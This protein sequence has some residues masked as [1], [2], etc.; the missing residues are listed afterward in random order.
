MN[1]NIKFLVSVNDGGQLHT[2][3]YSED[4]YNNNVMP[5][6]SKNYTPDQYSVTGL[7][8]T[9]SDNITE[10]NQYLISVS[11]NGHTYSKPYSGKDL[12]GGKLTEISRQFPDY[13]IQYIDGAVRVD[14][15][16]DE[17][18]SI[19]WQK[20]L[21]NKF[22]QLVKSTTKT[23]EQTNEVAEEVKSTSLSDLLAERGD[24]LRNFANMAVYN[25]LTKTPEELE[26]MHAKELEERE[27]RRREQ[28]DVQRLEETRKQISEINKQL[29][30][31]SVREQAA[32]EEDFGG[33]NIDWIVK[34][35]E[36]KAKL[37]KK[38][39]ELVKQQSEN[40]MY[41]K[42]EKRIEGIAED[43]RD[44]A[45]KVTSDISVEG[46]LVTYN[47]PEADTWQAARYFADNAL[48]TI[49]APDDTANGF[50][51]FLKGAGDTFSDVDFWTM[52]LESISSNTK[53]KRVFNKIADKVN[54]YS[55]KTLTETDFDNILTDA[56]KELIK[57][58]VSTS[59]A[60]ALRAYDTNNMY[61]AGSIAADSVGF[62]AQFILTGGVGDAFAGATKTAAK[63]FA[64]WIA[65]NTGKVGKRAAIDAAVASQT[66]V[67]RGAVKLADA[68]ATPVLKAV[69]MTLMQTGLYKNY[70]EKLTERDD[71]G[72][73]TYDY[74]TA[75]LPAL[76]D[77]GLE[78]WSEMALEPVLAVFGKT[79]SKGIANLP[80][81]SK[82]GAFM[83]TKLDDITSF[84][85]NREAIDLLTKAGFDGYFEEIGE[86]ILAA[87]VSSMWEPEAWSQF[88]EKDNLISMAVAF[89]PMS[90]IGGGMSMANYVK[91]TMA[92]EEAAPAV[93]DMLL[94]RTNITEAQLNALFDRKSATMQDIADKIS[95]IVKPIIESG[96]ISADEFKALYDFAGATAQKDIAQ[97]LMDRMTTDARN[98]MRAELNEKT[99]GKTIY[100]KDKDGNETV[101]I[102]TDANGKKRYVIIDETSEDTLALS[103][104]EQGGNIKIVDPS[105][106]EITTMPAN[107]YLDAQV[108]AAKQVEEQN[109]IAQQQKQQKQSVME[110]LKSRKPVKLYSPVSNL[111]E[112]YIFL[113]WDG[114][115]AVVA[116]AQTGDEERRTVQEMANALNISP[117][118]LTKDQ[119][120][121]MQV[122]K[123]K[124]YDSLARSANDY[125]GAPISYGDVSGSLLRVKSKGDEQGES[126]LEAQIVTESG[127][128][129]SVNVTPQQIEDFIAERKELIANAGAEANDRR[130]KDRERKA[131]QAKDAEQYREAK[132]KFINPDGSI[133]EG[134][135]LENDPRS[136]AIY[137]DGKYGKKDTDATLRAALTK[138]QERAQKAL[139]A[140]DNE[141]NPD[142]KQPLRDEYDHAVAALDTLDG[143]IAERNMDESASGALTPDQASEKFAEMEQM[144]LTSDE[145][146]DL[147]LQS[148]EET[149]ARIDAIAKP[150]VSTDIPAYMEEKRKYAELVAAE[151]KKIDYWRSILNAPMT[152]LERQNPDMANAR[153]RRRMLDILT[154]KQST[155]DAETLARLDAELQQV[156]E[157]FIGRAIA[158]INKDNDN[159]VIVTEASVA[160]RM[161]ELGS[162]DSTI[163]QVL[164]AIS[165]GDQPK[166]F[167]DTDT[168]VIY[169]V[170]ENNFDVRDSQITFV[171]ERQHKRTRARGLASV[172]IDRLGLT[173]L[174]E[175]EKKSALLAEMHKLFRG[176]FYDGKSALTIADELISYGVERVFRGDIDGVGLNETITNFVKNIDNERGETSN[177]SGAGAAS[178]GGASYRVGADGNA[179]VE[180]VGTTEVGGQGTGSAVGGEEESEGEVA[181]ANGSPIQGLESYS[182]DELKRLIENHIANTL[183]GNGID[184]DIVAIELHGSRGRGTARKDSDLDAVVEYRGDIREDSMFNILNDEDSR[185]V[186]D[187]IG[188]DI[189]PIRAEETGTMESYMKR[190]QEYDAQK[191]QQQAASENEA[192]FRATLQQAHDSAATS[193]NGN[194]L[195]AAFNK[196]KW[197]EG[198]VNLDLGGGKFDN[199]TEFLKGKGVENLIFDPFNRDAEWNKR[200]AEQ[201]Q[202][203]GVDSVTCNNVLNVIDNEASRENVIL[204]ASKAIKPEG[205]AYFYIYEGDKSGIGKDKGQGRWQ[206]NMTTRQYI[207]EISKYF[208]DVKRRGQLIEAKN[209]LPTDEQSVWSFTGAYDGNNE[210]RFSVANNNQQIFVSNALASL[211][212]IQMKSGNA[213]AWVNKIQQAGGLKKEEDKWIGLTDW[214]KE[215]QGDISKEDVAEYIREHQIRIEE[216]HYAG[217]AE[218]DAENTYAMVER[219]L[220][221]K[222]SNYIA[223]YY[224]QNNGENDDLYGSDSYEYALD[225][226]RKEMNDEFPYAI[227]RSH[228][229]VYLT[230]PYEETDDLQKWADKLG[231]NFAPQ[232][233]INST[234]LDYTTDGLI[235][236]REIALVVPTIEPYNKSDNIHFGDAGEGRAVAWIRFGSSKYYIPEYDNFYEFKKRI[237]EKYFPGTFGYNIPDLSKLTDEERAEYDRLESIKKSVPMNKSRGTVLVIDEIQSKRHQDGKEKGYDSVPD[238]PFR[239]SWDALAMKRM[240]RLAAE[241]GYDKIAWTSGQMQSDRYGLTKNLGDFYY[242]PNEDGTY[243][244]SA[245]LNQRRPGYT[246]YSDLNFDS[247]TVDRIGEIFGKEIA[248]KVS[249]G[250]GRKGYSHNDE[251]DWVTFSGRELKMANEGMRYFYDQ[252]LVNWM[253]K[254]G[255]K[256]GVQVSDL[257][258]MNLENKEGWHSIDITPEM[259]ESVMEGQPMFRATEI[260]GN[261]SLIAVHNLTENNL[262]D[263]FD[264]GGFPMPSIAITKA[265]IGHTN[266]GDISLVFDKETIN[267]K[268]RKNKVYSGDAWTP[269]FPKIGYKLNYDKTREIYWRAIDVGDLP[270]FIPSRFER[271]NYE[272]NIDDMQAKSL[273]DN[274]KKDYGAKQFFLAE[275]GN[276][277]REYEMHEVDKYTEEQVQRFKEVLEKIGFENLRGVDWNLTPEILQVVRETLDVKSNVEDDIIKKIARRYVAN[278][279]DYATHG[280]KKSE[281]DYDATRRKI[282][283]RID[284]SA[285]EKWLEDLFSGIVEKRGIRN[286]VDPFTPIGNRRAWEKLYDEVTLDNVVKAMSKKPK[287][288]GS[289][290]FGG[291]IFGASAKTYNS[292][293][294]IRKEAASRLAAVKPEE[295]EKQKQ[296]ILDRLSEVKVTNKEL[297]LTEMFDLTE[298]IRDAVAKSHTADGIHRYLKD[299]YPDI[300]M[301]A[302]QEIADIVKDIQ[303]I[304][305]KYFEAKPYRAVGF[306]EVK[307]A[308][309]PEG[310][311]QA[312]VDGLLER[313]VPVR[314]YEKAN[315]QERMDIISNATEEMGLRFRTIEITPEVRDEMYQIEALARLKG[316]YLKAPNGADTK[317]NPEQWAMVRTKKFKDWFGDWELAAKILNIVTVSQNHGFKNFEEAKKWA[318]ANIVRT[319]SNEETG[320]KGEIRISNNAISKFL[321]ESA[322]SK[323]ES[324][325]IHLSVLK[326]LPD[327]IK[328]SLDAEQHPDY[329]KG[330]DGV[331]S[332]KNGI[333]EGVTIHRLYGA[334]SIDGQVYRTKV[335]IKEYADKNRPQKAYSY[336][337]TKIELFAGTLV[338]ADSSNPNTNNSIS[339]ANLLNGVEKSYS[340]GEYLIDSSK[341]VDENGE[342][343]VV[344]HGT[345]REF[346][347]FGNTDSANELG[348]G[349]YFT[350][351]RR[352][353]EAYTNPRLTDNKGKIEARAMEIFIDDMGHSEE[354]SYD[355]EFVHDY[356]EAYDMAETELFGKPRVMSGFLNVRNPRMV[357]DNGNLEE[358]QGEHDGVIDNTFGKRHGG[359]MIQSRAGES[360]M[361]VMVYNPNQIKSATDNNGEFSRE[362]DD[363]R[364]RVIPGGASMAERAYRES[365]AF[366]FTGSE[367]ISS[368][369][370]VAF[371]FRELENYATENSFIVF[372]KDGM[373]TILHTG[374]GDMR[375]TFVDTAAAV[376][377]YNDF[378]PDTVYLVHNHPSGRLV[379]SAAD[380]NEL[381]KLKDIFSGVPVGGIILDTVSGNY[382]YFD[383]GIN[384]EKTM[385]EEGDEFPVKV[386]SFDKIVFDK[387][388][389][390][391]LNERKIAGS[392]DVAAF[393]SA[394]RL[395][396]GKKLG[397]LLLNNAQYIVANYV[398]N[399]N[400]LTTRNADRIARQ[401][402]SVAVHSNANRVIMFGNFNFD[403]KSLSS[404]NS[405][406]KKASGETMSLLDVV[407]MNPD[408]GY[409]SVTN[410]TLH[411]RNDGTMFRV[412]PAQDAE[413]MDAVE[414]GDMEKAERMVRD[415]AMAAGYNLEAY[416]G[417]DVDFN[418]FKRV[419]HTNGNIWGSGFYF[420]D[421]EDAAA[422]WGERAKIANSSGDYK[423]LHT[424]LSVHNPLELYSD[425]LE[426]GLGEYAEDVISKLD[427]EYDADI[428][429]AI[430]TET[431]IDDYRGDAN[432]R[433]ADAIQELGFDAIQGYYY[434]EY[435]TMVFSP[436]QVKSA[437]P[438]TYDD[439]GK[440]IPL[441]E[442]FNTESDDIRFRIS[443]RSSEG[444]NL[445]EGQQAYFANSKAV[446][447]KGNLL[448]LYHGTSR[449]GFNEFRSGFF[450]TSKK[451]ADSYG[452]N[453]REGKLYDPNEQAS[454]EKVIAGDF[455]LG[456]MTFDSEEDRADFLAK[457]PL[458]EDAMTLSQ[459]NEAIDNAYYDGDAELEKELESKRDA[460]KKIEND[461]RDYEFDH[462]VTTTWN[463]LLANPSAYTENDFRRAFLAYDSNAVFDDIDDM[464]PEDRIDAYIDALNYAVEETA[465][466]GGDALSIEFYSRV[467][468]N[469]EG[470]R[471]KDMRH[472]TYKVYINVENPFEMDAKGRHSEFESGYVYESIKNAMADPQYDGVIVRNWRVGRYQELGDVV[473]PKDK[474]Q[475]K[476][477]TN[478][479]PTESDDIRFRISGENA[480][481]AEDG[482]K[483]LANDIANEVYRQISSQENSGNL[484]TE[485]D[486]ESDGEVLFRFIGEIGA[487]RL[488]KTDGGRRILNLI[489]AKKYYTPESAENIKRAYGW[490]LDKDAKGSPV[491]KY[492]ENDFGIKDINIKDGAKLSDVI[493]DEGLF[494]AYPELKNYTLAIEDLKDNVG[495]FNEVNKK[496]ALEKGADKEDA[497]LTLIHEIQHFIQSKEGWVSGANSKDPLILDTVKD[498]F[499]YIRED[500]NMFLRS[501]AKR[502]FNKS[503]KKES[504]SNFRFF[505][506]KWGF[507]PIEYLFDLKKTDYLAYEAYLRNAGEVEARNAE[508]R[509]DMTALE[510][511]R[512]LAPETEDRPRSR[513]WRE[514]PYEDV[515]FSVS[516]ATQL[517]KKGLADSLTEE[518]MSSITNDAFASMDEQTRRKIAAEQIR[519]GGDLV[520]PVMDYISRIAETPDIAG[521][522]QMDADIIEGVRQ[523]LVK[524]VDAEDGDIT[525]NDTLWLVYD[526]VHGDDTYIYDAIKNR[527]IR[528][529]LGQARSVAPEMS[530]DDYLKAAEEAKDDIIAEYRA[531]RKLADSLISV[532]DAMEARRDFDRVTV[533]RVV[534]LA[535]SVMSSNLL[536][537]MTKGEVKR[538][539]GVIRRATG[540]RNIQTRIYEL[541]NIILNNNLRR[542]KNLFEKELKRKA[543][544]VGSKNVVE[545]G[546]LDLNGQ[547]IMAA[548]KDNLDKIAYDDNGQV[549]VSQALF[550]RINDAM[551]RSYSED[552]AVSNDAELELIG[553]SYARQYIEGV[554]ASEKEE[555][556]IKDSLKEADQS[557]ADGKLD[558]KSHREFVKEQFRALA[559]CRTERVKA[560]T[561]LVQKVQ[562]MSAASHDLAIKFVEQNKERIAQIHHDANSDLEGVPANEHPSEPTKK[563]RLINSSVTKFFLR[564]LGTFDMLLRMLGR[565]SPNGEGYLWNRFMRGWIDA[566][567]NE[568]TGIKNAKMML[569][570]K[571]SEIFG[572]KMVWSDLYSMVN[573]MPK[574]TVKFWDGGEMREHEVTQGNLLYIMLADQMTDGRMKLRAMGITEDDVDAI[575]AQM[576]SRFISLA[577]WIVHDF[578]PSRR[579][580]YNAV[581]ERMFGAPMSKVQNYFPLRILSNARTKQV[582]VATGNVEQATPSTV[583]GNIMKRTRNAL[584]LDI[585]GTDAFVLV[586]DHVQKMEHWAAFAEWNRD[587]SD[588]LSYKRFRN[589][590]QNM[591]SIYGAKNDLYNEF[592]DVAMIAAGSYRTK[593]TKVDVAAGKLAKGVTGAKISFRLYTAMKQLQSAIA[594]FS[595][596]NPIYIAEGFIKGW[597]WSKENL[598]MFEKRI[599]ARDMG[600][601]NLS[602]SMLPE[603]L[604]K[605]G[606]IGMSPNVGVDA[607]T[608]SAGAY[609]LYK[610]KYENYIKMGF[611]KEAADK[612]AKQDAVILYNETQQSSE[613]AFLS[614]LQ[615]DRTWLSKMLSVFRNSSFAYTR[616]V[617]DA[618]RNLAK[619]AESGYKRTS[620]EYLTKQLIR[621]GLSDSK[622]L[623]AAKDIYNR[624]G[625]KDMLRLA[626]Y[627]Y[628][629]PMTWGLLSSLP[630]LIFGDDDDKKEEM[631]DEAMLRMVF[632]PIEGLAAGNTLAEFGY[633]LSTDMDFKYVNNTQMPIVSDIT[634]VITEVKS[635]SVRAL[636]DIVNLA[637]QMLTGANPQTFEDAIIGII[638]A[639]N[640]DLGTTK[641]ALLLA[642]K[643]INAPQSS[644]DQLYLDEI[645]MSAKEASGLS[646]P[647]LASRY[648]K[649]KKMR[650]AG[651]FTPLYSFNPELDEKTTQKYIRQFESKAKERMKIGEENDFAEISEEAKALNDRISS[652]RKKANEGDPEADSQLME[653]FMSPDYA[654]LMRFYKLNEEM[655]SYINK[656]IRAKSNEE[657]ADYLEEANR[658]RGEMVE[659]YRNDPSEKAYF[660]DIYARY[661]YGILPEM[662][663]LDKKYKEEYA[664][665]NPD[666]L[667]WEEQHKEERAN[668]AAKAEAN[669]QK[670]LEIDAQL[671]KYEVTLPNGKKR[672]FNMPE[673]KRLYAE[674][675]RIREEGVTE[676]QILNR[677]DKTKPKYTE[678]D[679]MPEDIYNSPEYQI[680]LEMRELGSLSG[681][682]FKFKSIESLEKQLSEEGN[683]EQR[684]YLIYKINEN[685][686]AIAKEISAKLIGDTEEES[687]ELNLD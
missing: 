535:N 479:N 18:I 615:A 531:L 107:Q 491:W 649:Y 440:I 557:L 424:Y 22:G 140:R 419:H 46:D 405:S 347:T 306:D 311:S 648:A 288:G 611:S 35:A 519:L 319:L 136:Y 166:G 344:Y 650:N 208:G 158:D 402:A 67:G 415:A 540:M 665:S 376:A 79:I 494:A 357:V 185:L 392:N 452:G 454:S 637:T 70:A 363:I 638:D 250:K 260:A 526:Y 436:N 518:Q 515:M 443:A 78:V 383:E 146:I 334:V 600:D 421:S 655:N 544:K 685:K 470:T 580:A 29:G 212:K 298:N 97:A 72:N 437:D 463:D 534:K 74:D 91:R 483:E 139:A 8:D 683:A 89:A 555:Q 259:K 549:V 528:R 634:N 186:I 593:S 302:A 585:M 238:A 153:M 609:A 134:E 291:N 385:P 672:Y 573:R 88:W 349:F 501:A 624:Q 2:N 610:T 441:S 118:I 105:E 12:L 73:L 453:D 289:G 99:G 256:W 575:R 369:D 219:I 666:Y 510:R 313:G 197:Q 388:F 167:Y 47:N 108:T 213:Q 586:M 196:I 292:I 379:A 192:L 543:S 7:Q 551:D 409:V 559:E 189:N 299:Y 121:Q 172:L 55:D 496:I 642:L 558:K 16:S 300:T 681:N 181:Y 264:L 258:L 384:I 652:L 605:V 59:E 608:V 320:G 64:K 530:L 583:T 86:E 343:M 124:R 354:D 449:A 679:Y 356:N 331:R 532:M 553:L 678:E 57:S 396:K 227:E 33:E 326:V 106:L 144:G 333:N 98:N 520:Q 517:R 445:S 261:P 581:H 529:A 113:G 122:E 210:L 539:T 623:R 493:D 635:D 497:R 597:K 374:I 247:L 77:A 117:S 621:E 14:D 310:T 556:D 188:V 568:Y 178:Y 400:S 614:T 216:V 477:T 603:F 112:D 522:S 123:S 110:A 293:S 104:D 674:K 309:V 236:K 430:R 438:V 591:T 656:A 448:T 478:I 606:T 401:V 668:A 499:P 6:L 20:Q 554:A 295:I 341:V 475:I 370:D 276:P 191:I 670:I 601:Q 325:D 265:D 588:L 372:V 433:I 407:Q 283:E 547:K 578:L 252:K 545:Q 395:G 417:T 220:N 658:L 352:L 686:M 455:R 378:A 171:H 232:N 368:I 626:I 533:G 577:D 362:N 206:N 366:S 391:Q 345:G 373:P 353:A 317:L 351:N 403:D 126:Y 109:Q 628:I 645:D 618:S 509:A 128:V 223:E 43:I 268:N 361:Q 255:K 15:T 115:M 358:E 619:R 279:V 209:P 154:E 277:I 267:P 644:I 527:R 651:P 135:W 560:F 653:I 404:F 330:E 184:A 340:P 82:V 230:F 60:Q 607:F 471:V 316:K 54:N 408:G 335:T 416:H 142:F 500:L 589:K 654:P 386:L 550:D 498:I 631:L 145:I 673:R 487:D 132:A 245:A 676:K 431:P 111:R 592:V 262:L 284:Q 659:D 217:G 218:D 4:E 182:R 30:E 411:G 205:I 65:K 482:A 25:G 508:K 502:I 24:A 474:N 574:A 398:T 602:Q 149:Q 53:V 570:A 567:S 381:A 418:E 422:G 382:G 84:L 248:A 446:D 103:M 633:K 646:I 69:P 546:R 34:N 461:Y 548:L 175:E 414:A 297:D 314:T 492:E 37:L 61:N 371:I 427:P 562:D 147:A 164:K 11:S 566:T 582:D 467:P 584:A 41:R 304:S 130:A 234:R 195:P 40:P 380:I 160:D 359:L 237:T 193:I 68:V 150:Q 231:I 595:D 412:T 180:G 413:Y 512:S 159:V 1:D 27:A 21:S 669:A 439:N 280:N 275:Q 94:N 612:R 451:D 647:E 524:M 321:S 85:H 552:K 290:F 56:E 476:L 350:D 269:T 9:I 377:G 155:K 3:L 346:Y 538:I 516:P 44:K 133:R 48:K 17:I 169:M 251:R 425:R 294:D 337:A 225:K 214:L 579:E 242:K 254:Y 66:L 177:L 129:V 364:Y 682:T 32:G 504:I 202:A 137:S 143:L 161:R 663:R 472:R 514:T 375:S 200:I 51:A 329:K 215:Q 162:K 83:K 228:S 462:L 271:V 42:E 301:G 594:Y 226:L 233:P 151:Q 488:D 156:S 564:P 399:D 273:I 222:F 168:G 434:D 76:R 198:S 179:A 620:I 355:N 643:I 613:A 525:T 596:A 243:K 432:D 183:S 629:L 617:V 272:D 542:L 157:G 31:W 322:I 336:E 241:E 660:R 342:P 468:R 163:E 636:N 598:P 315:Q 664:E 684:D 170:A 203:G 360:A 224:E 278:A 257:T 327:V 45:Y 332:V 38:R 229:D 93:R 599:K 495:Y 457:H 464:D 587:L 447:E 131:R 305:T 102:Y 616:Q 119:Q 71:A 458:A 639:C 622:A 459:L 190:S 365:G 81:A 148:I 406:F 194:K 561:E 661:S 75:I 19:P 152:E 92:Y 13:H 486:S 114:D 274:L 5:L 201:V 239:D 426:L 456:Y 174:S 286:E 187:G 87:G 49:N 235:D 96:A 489:E 662:S 536:D 263:A 389:K 281:V 507:N 323:S 687:Y 590:V 576:D 318:K 312:V 95:D 244:V 204:Q 394:H 513:Q 627:G 165:D 680:Y 62:M 253:N 460:Y 390:S 63:G 450:T 339:A 58:F 397:V 90:V 120:T 423:V 541:Y 100:G 282:D 387:E 604:E 428:I 36:R 367:R 571:V 141:S 465:A 39:A 480:T 442:R 485:M 348:A 207:P 429:D 116:N 10:D 505:K 23:M 308:I 569:D 221:E 435:H 410:D 176:N 285:F 641:E 671:N 138:A 469:G 28:E 677:I 328:E 521:I 324:K 563:D 338:G 270:F 506:D 630:Y 199:A 420:A 667:A 393:L 444:E 537:N 481:F 52:G 307:L 511:R 565:M 246:D 266:F 625:I 296:A 675:K 303:S 657:M 101:S 50:N 249:E 632:G 240:L 503:Y 125:K 572:R 26:A 287:R 173:G 490:E 211:D 523:N 80:K 473:V 127:E 640:G 466:E 484:A